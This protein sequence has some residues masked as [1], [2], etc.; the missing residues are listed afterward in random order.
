MPIISNYPFDKNVQDNDA[1]IGTDAS[2]MS[3]KQFT[4]LDLS[5]IHI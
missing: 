2:N 3:T 1:W 4:A 5:L